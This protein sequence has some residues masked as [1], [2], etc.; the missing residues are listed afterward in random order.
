[1]IA[2]RVPIS[3]VPMTMER[4]SELRLSRDWL[5]I[6]DIIFFLSMFDVKDFSGS[7]SI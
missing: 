1:M 5:A 2:S 6:A 3:S 7:T 4:S